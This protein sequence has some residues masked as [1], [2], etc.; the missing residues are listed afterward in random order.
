MADNYNDLFSPDSDFYK[1]RE[2]AHNYTNLAPILEEKGMDTSFAIDPN[3]IPDPID[4]TDEITDEVLSNEK[5]FQTVGRILY[6][7][8]ASKIAATEEAYDA[9]E[10]GIVGGRPEMDINIIAKNKRRI[11]RTDVEFGKYALEQLGFFNF[12]M[13]QMGYDTLTMQKAEPYQRLAFYY[14]VNAYERLKNFTK[15]GT[16]RFFSGVVSDPSTYLGLGSLG[17]V[18]RQLAKKTGGKNVLLNLIKNAGVTSA[19]GGVEGGA[20]GAMD[21]YFR[22]EIGMEAGGQKEFNFDELLKAAGYGAAAGGVLGG[23]I[24]VAGA[25]GKGAVDLA[26]RVEIDDS[27][28]LGS[29]NIPLRLKPKETTISRKPFF[30]AVEDAVNNISMEKGTG[31]QFLGMLQNTQGVKQEEMDWIGLTDYL[32]ENKNVTKKDVQEYVDFNKVDIEEITKRPG[33]TAEDSNYVFGETV[34]DTDGLLDWRVAYEDNYALNDVLNN[35]D[36]DLVQRKEIKDSILNKYKEENTTPPYNF[37]M[38]EVIEKELSNPN[39]KYKDMSPEV[40]TR[41]EEYADNRMDDMYYDRDNGIAVE[42]LVNEAS[43]VT[44]Q[45]NDELGYLIYKEEGLADSYKNAIKTDPIYSFEEAKIQADEVARDYGLMEYEGDVAKWEEWTA[46]GGTN[47][48]EVLFINNGKK[49]E[50][51]DHSKAF[52]EGG[53]YEEENILAHVRLKDRTDSSGAKVLF[54]EEIQ[55]DWLQQ[56]RKKGFQ[57][58]EKEMQE[59]AAKRKEAQ[60]KVDKYTKQVKDTG[61][62]LEGKEL[63]EANTLSNFLTDTNNFVVRNDQKV[64]DAPLKKTWQETMFRRIVRMAAEEGYDK[65]SWTPGK[66]QAD[67]YSLRRAVDKI[68]HYRID[69]GKKVSIILQGSNFR[70]QQQSAFDSPNRGSEI[71]V[72]RETGIIE[73]T[74]AGMRVLQEIKGKNLSDVLGKDITAKILTKEGNGVIEGEDLSIGGEGMVEFYDKMIRRYADKWG[75]KFDAKTYVNKIDGDG[76]NDFDS[77]T[78][79]ITPDMKQKVLEKGVPL[80]SAG[81]GTVTAGGI[82]AAKQKQEQQ[83]QDNSI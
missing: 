13:A 64:P 31:E 32:K 3:F 66:M 25:V 1:S 52:S 79:N 63:D 72:N 18:T 42:R 50:P 36:D 83:T 46:P 17:L 49:G 27:A 28:T 34:K 14:G 76:G 69:D 45:G 53:H 58:S 20:Y 82:A 65:V 62:D 29:T 55:S 75:K 57:K 44:I 47:Y 70:P 19:V 35:I 37:E 12:N 33:V 9:P 22:Q 81:A 4:A 30:S 61:K 38:P 6:D 23:V 21:N 56:G 71:V 5:N 24:P 43:G 40:Q 74:D 51:F 78:M 16:G 59:I 10:T 8:D 39:L 73:Q 26:K 11:P 80:F 77:L 41:I 60:A 67:R 7:M 2:A 15:K 48:R 68:N 54:I